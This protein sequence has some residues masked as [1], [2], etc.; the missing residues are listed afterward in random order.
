[1]TQHELRM[2][3]DSLFTMS[4][5][6]DVSPCEIIK[7]MIGSVLSEEEAGEIINSYNPPLESGNLIDKTL[8]EIDVTQSHECEKGN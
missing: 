1:M 3:K 5:I 7:C 8:K 4:L 6:L 2:I